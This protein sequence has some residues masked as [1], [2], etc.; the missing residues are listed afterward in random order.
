MSRTTGGCACA[1]VRYEFT[2]DPMMMGQ[3]Q[4]R[5]CQ[6]DSGAGHACHI[7][8]AADGFRMSGPIKYW[9]S[10]ADSGN[11]VARGFCTECGS[12]VASRNA[13]MPQMA[14]VRAAS[15][16]DP[17]LFKPQL[18]VWASKRQPWDHVDAALP[19]FAT[20]PPGM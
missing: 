10:R 4:C 13:G 9:E 6:R 14:F 2:G 7:A 8:V 16:D 20:M 18:V 5:A 12:P 19:T 15:L 17:T 11:V 1:A 3:C